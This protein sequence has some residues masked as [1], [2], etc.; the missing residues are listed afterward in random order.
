MKKE[1]KEEIIT[2]EEL[3]KITLRCYEIKEEILKASKRNDYKTIGKLMKEFCDYNKKLD[4]YN[5][6]LKHVSIES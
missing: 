3:E 6:Y 5:K 2:E 1:K 4:R